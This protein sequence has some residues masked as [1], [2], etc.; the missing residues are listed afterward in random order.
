V[1]ASDR[2]RFVPVNESSPA[3]VQLDPRPHPD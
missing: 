1:P 3:A 2:E